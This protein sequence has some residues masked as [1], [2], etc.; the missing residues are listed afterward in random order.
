M[1]ETITVANG[2]SPAQYSI[3]W[4]HGLGADGNDFVPIVRELDLPPTLRLRFVFPH[5]PVR[6]VTIN[7]GVRMRAWYDITGLGPG[8]RQDDAGIRDSTAAVEE[9][10][11]AEFAQGIAPERLILAGFSQGGAIAQHLALRHPQR[12]AGLMALSTYLPLA[13]T[14]AAQAAPANADIPIFQCH[15]SYDP[16]I[17]LP[18][19]TA[20]R[21]ILQ[22][23]G[24]PVTW[25]QYPM[26]HEVCRE[27]INDIREWLLARCAS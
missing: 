15:G 4:L 26:Q 2:D 12:L 7:N 16:M 3:I 27:Q 20:S 23:A 19:A 18:L 8:A 22:E 10:M 6:P 24:Y 13:E 11:A 14:L 21:D 17:P 25:R 1:L 9:L 5:A